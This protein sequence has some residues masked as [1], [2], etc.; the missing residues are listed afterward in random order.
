MHV[1]FTTIVQPGSKPSQLVG[2]MGSTPTA[3]E[4]IKRL[5]TESISTT[6][7]FSASWR[8]RTLPTAPEVRD[9]NNNSGF[10]RGSPRNPFLQSKPFQLA[11]AIE[12]FQQEAPK[13]IQ[14]SPSKIIMYYVLSV[15]YHVLCIVYHALMYQS[16]AGS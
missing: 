6:E 11:G 2:A 8:H 14:A 7:A 15:L 13:T 16:S 1:I 4:V 10:E 3:P 12:R 5:P 9:S